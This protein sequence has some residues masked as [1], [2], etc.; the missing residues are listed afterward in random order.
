MIKI[1]RTFPY[2][3]NHVDTMTLKHCALLVL[4]CTSTTIHA[5]SQTSFDTPL[6]DNVIPNSNGHFPTD[7]W[8]PDFKEVKRVSRPTMLI[9]TPRQHK[10]RT[11]AVIIFPGGG[12]RVEEYER[13]GTAIAMELV[14]Q[15]VTCFVVRY[16]LPDSTTMQH[17]ATGPITDA[18]QAIQLVRSQA[19]ALLIDPDRIGVMGFSAGGHL[20]AMA[21]TQFD[22]VYAPRM[23][24]ISVR[25]NF[26]LL[27]YPVISM[28]DPLAHAGS[29]TALLGDSASPALR[30]QFSN[31][32]HVTS[33]TPPTYLVYADDDKTVPPRNSIVFYQQL[34]QHG[35]EAQLEHFPTGGHGFAGGRVPDSEWMK[36]M[37]SWMRRSGW[38][39][40]LD[41]PE[42]A[43]ASTLK[44][45]KGVATV[46]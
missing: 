12:Y 32:M 13:E 37:I 33:H 26:M 42:Q 39:L 41:E 21:G 36:N 30:E 4:L 16:R 27:V 44:N 20:A 9:I 10:Q 8:T 18:Q 34:R 15:N 1:Y 24:G 2:H 29:R 45:D 6:Y 46:K 28:E 19:K 14:K 3:Q 35:V 43:P 31:E 17:P 5:Q 38:I 40:D 23:D 25:P 22:S 7:E 11:S